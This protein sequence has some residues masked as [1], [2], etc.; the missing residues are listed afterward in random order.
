MPLRG[1][2]KKNG[3]LR[4]S[5]AEWLRAGRA[6]NAERPRQQIK[7]LLPQARKFNPELYPVGIR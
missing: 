4:N 5:N 3:G 7:E 6:G 2:G 1:G